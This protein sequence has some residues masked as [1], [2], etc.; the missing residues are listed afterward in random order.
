MK[1]KK[2]FFPFDDDIVKAI[3]VVASS[4]RLVA[5]AINRVAD[6]LTKPNPQPLVTQAQ[7]DEMAAGVKQNSDAVVADGGN[8]LLF[9]LLLVLGW[10]VF[11]A[12]VH[13]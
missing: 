6:I 12:P 9:I 7:L 10:Q 3:N 11:G 13:R 4:N 2:D 5:A 8:F 1:P